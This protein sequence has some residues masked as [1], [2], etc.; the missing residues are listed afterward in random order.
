[1]VTHRLMAAMFFFFFHFVIQLQSLR[2][3]FQFFRWR[4]HQ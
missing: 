1:M 4:H 3:I 2:Y